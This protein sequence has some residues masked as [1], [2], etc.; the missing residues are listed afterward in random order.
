MNNGIEELEWFP[1]GCDLNP[2]EHVWSFIKDQL[3]NVKDKLKN[4]SDVFKFS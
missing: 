4:K 2:I 3:Y 1:K